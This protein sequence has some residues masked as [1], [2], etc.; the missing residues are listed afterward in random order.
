MIQVANDNSIELTRGDS[1]YIRVPIF[2]NN[3]EGD[4]YF[5]DPLDKLIFSLKK[6]ISDTEYAFQKK[7]TGDN[8]FHIE[9]KD[10]KDLEYGSYRYDVELI[11]KTGDVF[12]VIPPTSF[13]LTSEVTVDG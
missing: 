11:T 13:K 8:V 7:L 10:T 1:A 12:T 4:E 2:L 9:P 5:L 3:G 6:S